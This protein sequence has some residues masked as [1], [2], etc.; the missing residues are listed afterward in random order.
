MAG[1]YYTIAIVNIDDTLLT[2]QYRATA[3]IK[4]GTAQVGDSCG[5]F[6]VN[7]DGPYTIGFAAAS[8]WQ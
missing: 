3:T 6:A 8:C 7:Q 2:T 1:D 5:T 4:A